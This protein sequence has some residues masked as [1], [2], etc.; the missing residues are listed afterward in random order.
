MKS[1]SPMKTKTLLALSATCAAAVLCA[2]P[3][4]EGGGRRVERIVK[5]Y[6]AECGYTNS[7]KEVHIVLHPV[8]GK[9]GK[10][11]PLYVVLHSSGHDADAALRCTARLGNH[12]IYRAPDDFYALYLDCRMAKD[13]DWWWGANGCRGFRLS[14]CERRLLSTIEETVEK[15]SIDRDR[16]YLCGNSMGGS[17]ALGLGLRHGDV[18]AAVK[19]NVPALVEHACGR[20][21]WDMARDADACGADIASIPEPPLL[22]DYS[23]QNDKWSSGH[24]HLVS[25]MRARRYPWMFLW[26]DFGHA[27][28]DSSVLA[29]NDVVNALDWTNVRRS[30]VLPAFTN[31]SCDDSVPWPDRRDSKAPGQINAFFR[32]K[33][34][35]ATETSVSIDLF[36]ADM[37]SRHFA[38]PDRA[39]ADVTLRRLGA[40]KARRGDSFTWT[41]AGR[42][43]A[44]IVGADGALTVPSLEISKEPR[45]LVVSRSAAGSGS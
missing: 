32:W 42:S 33:G 11:R 44:A 39:V 18:F 9:E 4:A 23:A 12:D 43:G 38:V 10:G 30:D 41:C 29:K 27:N 25:M 36:L 3:L 22:V 7:V 35:K 37:K 16:I 26:A 40:L 15:Y 45:T 17:G 6:G 21:G 31:A 13:S 28:A 34:G 20:M 1:S 8:P 19:A 2:E 14:P 24:E 5:D